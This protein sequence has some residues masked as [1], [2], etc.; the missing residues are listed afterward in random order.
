MRLVD[1]DRVIRRQ[2]GVALDLRKQNAIRRHHQA[3][4]GRAFVGEA[5]AEA[6]LVAQT[7]AGFLRDA[8]RHRAG[9]DTPWLREHDLAAMRAAAFFQ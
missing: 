7:C 6:D 4:G 8:L 5:H 2:F 9:G 1:H 3:R